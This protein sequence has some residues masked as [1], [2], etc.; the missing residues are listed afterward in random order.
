MSGVLSEWG[1]VLD[2]YHIC[3]GYVINIL[4][5]PTLFGIRLNNNDNNNCLTFIA[6]ESLETKL[7]GA[8]VQQG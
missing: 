2:S 7:R 5:R 3:V 1:F 4:H 6:P 8:S